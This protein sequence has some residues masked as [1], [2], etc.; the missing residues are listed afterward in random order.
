MP[1]AT[2][3]TTLLSGSYWGG[4]EVTNNP[5]FITYSFAATAPP[6]DAYNL[7]P[8]AYAT[9]TPYTAAQKAQAQQAL[10]EWSSASTVVGGGSGITFLE[11]E[12][13]QGDINFAAYDFSTDYYAS[14]AGGM[15]FY[16]WGNWNYST[17]GSNTGRFGADLDGPGNILM[18]TAYATGGLFAY[19]TVLHEIGHALGLKH[20]TEAWTDNVPG[21][22]YVEHNQWDPNVAYNAAFSVMSTGASPLTHLAAADLQAVQSVYGT[23]AMAANQTKSWSWN[24]GTDTLTQTLKD[25]GVTVRGVSTNNII[26]GGT[27][28]DA[29]YAIGDG[30][31]LV[32]GR[33]GD[34]NLVGGSGLSTLIG[35]AGGDILNG[36]FGASI[37][38]YSDAKV[39]VLVNLAS[40]WLN[41]GDAAGD[42][43]L[44]IHRV[45]GSKY[46]DT[47]IGDDSGVT[48]WGRNGNDTLTGGSGDDTLIGGAG[49]DVIDGGGGT[50]WADYSDATKAVVVDLSLAT[51]QNTKGAGN[52]Q[53]SNLENLRGSGFDDTLAAGL[54]AHEIDGGAGKDTA[55]YL[56]AAA[57][58]TVD[59]A[60]TGFQATGGSG[61]HK[62]TSIESLLGSNF[63]DTLSGDGGANSLNGG[64]GDDTLIGR[65][66]TDILTGGAG[67]DSMTGG[68]DADT[69]Y[70]AAKGDTGKTFATADII[71]DF[72][73]AQHDQIDLSKIDADSTLTGDQA[74]VLGGSAFTHLAGELI[75]TAQSG[76]WLVQ[77]DTN[78]DAKVDF[79]IFVQAPAALLAGDFIL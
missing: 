39:A 37:A 64:K 75:Q 59:L 73:A 50:D 22:I 67:K 15:A 48:L 65:G 70:F 1:F 8:S 36:W 63:A 79:A 10:A 11:V 57:G 42:I 58:V 33:A 30:V 45:E 78:G 18:N 60:L 13:G 49:N 66:G 5:V 29:I 62:L 71:T 44:N 74:F 4:P 20:P 51:V 46:A 34:D 47:L 7:S 38:S 76:G 53:L 21:W 6:S 69:F 55:S 43:Y 2:D 17:F 14:G 28:A 41:T 61:S 9:F 16:P 54:G 77:A 24:A 23:K 26:T 31:N 27:G 72:S 52:D 12:P 19:E 56:T 25:G 3:Y 40:P 35:G 32:N 68:A